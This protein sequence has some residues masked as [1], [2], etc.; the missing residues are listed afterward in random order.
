[1]T[2][3][4]ATRARPRK[5]QRLNQY[6][7]TLAEARRVTVFA[8]KCSECGHIM[9]LVDESKP[10]VRCS[11]RKGGCGRVFYNEPDGESE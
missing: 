7:Q 9:P 11:N 5:N 4:T 10:P 2:S 8:W 1:M 3:A 6:G